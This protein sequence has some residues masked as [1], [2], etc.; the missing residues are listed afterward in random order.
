MR[1]L[2]P[3]E[4]PSISLSSV[5]A[6]GVL[7]T[8]ECQTASTIAGRFLAGH[9]RMVTS[10]TRLSVANHHGLLFRKTI[11]ASFL[12]T[13]QSIVGTSEIFTCVSRRRVIMSNAHA[14]GYTL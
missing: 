7:P 9:G 12:R 11:A 10:A 4:L 14:N 3:K 13:V 5:A 1:P 8:L 2:V 6:S